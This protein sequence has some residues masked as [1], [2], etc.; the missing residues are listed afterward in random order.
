MAFFT[1][2]K[3]IKKTPPKTAA[4]RFPAP[5]R[6]P[7]TKKVV[8]DENTCASI[9]TV[10]SENPEMR[11]ADYLAKLGWDKN[12]V[13]S[14]FNVKVQEAKKVYERNLRESGGTK[15]PSPAEAAQRGMYDI[16]LNLS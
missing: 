10:V 14:T 11:P 9:Y 2:M 5:S 16:I 7:A 8:W 3:S 12:D 13:T 15:L 6:D 1:P 4:R